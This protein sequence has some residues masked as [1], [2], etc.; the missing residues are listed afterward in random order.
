[1][2]TTSRAFLRYDFTRVPPAETRPIVESRASTLSVGVAG[3]LTP[4]ISADVTVGFTS[5]SAPRAAVEGRRYRGSTLAATLRK[6]F[7]PSASVTLLGSRGT[8]PSGFEENA[9]YIATG[10]GVGT[11]LGLPLSFVFHGGM[12]WQRNAYRVPAAGLSV[13]RQDDIWDWSVGLGRSLTRWSFLRADY[14]YE[15]RDSNLPA[16][17]TDGHLFMVQLG[18]GFIGAS[19]TGPGNR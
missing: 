1:M 17:Q 15:R 13:P 11:D 16:F 6:E 14:R 2:G 18:F 12:A 5:L 8:Y 19:P 7:T 4:L 10:A 9:F 3:E